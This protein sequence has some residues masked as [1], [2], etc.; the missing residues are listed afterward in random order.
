MKRLLLL[1]V[2]ALSSTVVAQTKATNRLHN[3]A[4]ILDEIMNIPE[5]GIPEEIFANAKCVAVVPH[6]I[7]AGFV[8]GIEHGRGVATCRVGDGWSAPV[9]FTITGGNWGLQIGVEGV[10]LV[11][12]THTNEGMERLLASKMQ[13]GVDASAAAGPIGRHASADSDWRFDSEVLTYS[14]AKGIFAG[15]TIKGAGVRKDDDSTKAYYRNNYSTREL[16]G[17]K[18][19]SQSSATNE[20]IAAVESAD[21]KSKQ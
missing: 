16:L 21:Y 10:D 15:V 11:M 14:R 18:V 9:F 8:F 3:S 2:L 1:F 12:L 7:K 20:F 6:M 17:G 13:I 5:R 19:Q 4:T